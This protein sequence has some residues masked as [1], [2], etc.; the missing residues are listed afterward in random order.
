[1]DMNQRLRLWFGLPETEKATVLLQTNMVAVV[2]R[3][4]DLTLMRYR[5]NPLFGQ[6]AA[7]LQSATTF[8]DP[9][10]LFDALLRDCLPRDR[11]HDF[12]E[13]ALG[14]E[15]KNQF[16]RGAPF[17][18]LIPDDGHEQRVKQAWLTLT[19]K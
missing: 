10:A 15:A 9:A 19:E 11:V 2:G 1:M 17:A 18:D 7:A 3:G 12:L 4:P 16:L 8:K 5:N 13:A 6:A 14:E